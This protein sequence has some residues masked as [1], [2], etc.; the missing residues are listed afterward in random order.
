[1][2][3]SGLFKKAVFISLL[4]HLTLFSVFSFSFGNRIPFRNSGNVYFWG[5]ILSHA[6]F[7]AD[8]K[9]AKI[10][11]KRILL[12][13]RHTDMAPAK[14]KKEPLLLKDLYFKPAITPLLNPN[15]IFIPKILFFSFIP[16]RS[17]QAITFHPSLPEHFLLFFKD[18]QAVHIELMFNVVS[19]KDKA[20]SIVVRREISSGNPEADLLSMRYIGHYLF[21]EQG[22]FSTDKWQAVKIDLSAQK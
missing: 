9:R 7:T 1:M 16:K 3:S 8:F 13:S 22:R 19:R 6:D 15:K 11:I 14:P 4:G 21:I 5:A 12:D 2:I 10:E 18:R 20:N 17:D